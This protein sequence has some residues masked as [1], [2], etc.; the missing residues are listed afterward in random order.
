MTDYSYVLSK[1]YKGDEWVLRGDSYDGLEWLSQKPKPTK[2][3]LDSEYAKIKAEEK[4]LEYMKNRCDALPEAK[5]LLMLLYHD[6]VNGTSEFKALMKT[7][8]DK[9]PK[10]S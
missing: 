1:V 8:C 2:E 7:V 10:P 9:Y 5:E 4:S 6:E 3:F